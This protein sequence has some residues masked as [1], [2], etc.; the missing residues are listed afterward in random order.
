MQ[1]KITSPWQILP[2]WIHFSGIGGIA[3][4]QIAVAYL[5]KKY[6]VTGSDI[7]IYE[8][9]A[10][11][12]KQFPIQ[13]KSGYSYSNLLLSS[14]TN[15][16]K[17]KYTLPGKVIA[18]GGLAVN[19]KE[20]LF[21]LK[22][23][24]DIENFAQLLER[25]LIVENSLVVAGSYGKS[26]VTA[27]LIK[28]FLKA[29]LNISYMVGGITSDTERSVKLAD[30][31]TEYSIIEGD[32]YISSRTDLQ[33][34]FFHYKPK[35]LILTG[36]AYDHSDIFKT[37]KEY[38]DNFA[39]L[40]ALIPANGF[41]VYNSKLKEITELVKSARC[42]LLDCAQH[43]S[44]KTKLIGEY[45]QENIA[46]AI[47]AALELGISKSIALNAIA[48]FNGLKRRLEIVSSSPQLTIIDDFGSTPVKA[49]NVIASIRKKYPGANLIVVFEPNIGSRTETSLP[50]F[51]FSFIEADHLLIPEFNNIN[52]KGILDSNEFVTGLSRYYQNVSLISNTEL[53][54]KLKD[55]LI[56][57][58]SNIIAF[59]SSHDV[60]TKIDRF[61]EYMESSGNIRQ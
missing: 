35:Y 18:L 7:G 3:T 49:Q 1:S 14:Y 36:Y 27:L 46:A 26:T 28:I 30:K 53:N 61:I 13:L 51:Q 6:L 34:K 37:K 39:K 19:N 12:L 21:A 20:L 47:T 4:G 45:N 56:P 5:E 42:K 58:G 9:M 52:Q 2:N 15:N 41:I 11:F 29:E 31:D 8:P 10:S 60:R 57:T 40:I 48:E 38:Y 24:L 25:D 17:D 32:E 23:N 22:R 55:L 50:E 54:N 59:I 43:I 16:Q 33:S 44:Y